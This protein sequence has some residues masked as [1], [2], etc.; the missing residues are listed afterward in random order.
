MVQSVLDMSKQHPTVSVSHLRDLVA[1]ETSLILARSTVAR[2]LVSNGQHHPRVKTVRIHVRF[3]SQA[4]DQ[5]LQMDTTSGV[6]LMGYRLVY[7]I[8]VLDEYS[9]MVM[10]WKWVNSDSTLNN[11]LV[12]K[13]WTGTTPSM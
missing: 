13:Q 12:L 7:L 1:E 11:M 5:R 3:E 10:G 8:A 4:S 2:I 6:W 9:R